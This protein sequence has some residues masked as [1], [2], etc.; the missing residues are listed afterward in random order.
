MPEWCLDVG[1]WSLWSSCRIQLRKSKQKQKQKLLQKQKGKAKGRQEEEC[2]SSPRPP[3]P[4]PRP[5]SL[6]PHLPPPCCRRT[7]AHLILART[8]LAP[9]PPGRWPRRQSRPGQVGPRPPASPSNTTWRQTRPRTQHTR[10]QKWRQRAVESGS[11]RRQR[12]Q[13]CL[14]MSRR[15]ERRPRV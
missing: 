15:G 4:A 13:H 3:P 12:A 11:H 2:R 8:T 6:S 9:R 7:P 1:C 5:R 14:P 10:D